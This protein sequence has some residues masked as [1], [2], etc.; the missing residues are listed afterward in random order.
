MLLR[1]CTDRCTVLE[2]AQLQLGER[3]DHR[4]G[5][6]LVDLSVCLHGL[7]AERKSTDRMRGVRHPRDTCCSLDVPDEIHRVR[8][9]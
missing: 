6:D 3:P 8:L 5:V 7:H 4:M 9:H 2:Q 1:R